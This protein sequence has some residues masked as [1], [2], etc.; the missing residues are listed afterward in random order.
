MSLPTLSPDDVRAYISDFA[1][2]NY[3]LD[4]E[5]F[6]DASIA[7][8]KKLAISDYNVIPPV[9]Q[10]NDV[11]FPGLA[12]LLKGTVAHLLLGKAAHLA[13]NTMSYTDGGLQIP[14]EERSQL[15][16]E[17]GNQY[18]AQFK[19]EATKLKVHL[20]IESGWGYV[21]SDLQLTPLW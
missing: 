8:A 9:S 16:T 7:L 14:T 15:Y 21:S 17:L 4:G 2:R 19:D 20:N 18:L 3:L 10:V 12:L 11:T 6:S 1:D 5:E 13:R